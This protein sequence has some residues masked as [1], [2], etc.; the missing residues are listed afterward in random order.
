[1]RTGLIPALLFTA[2]G[3][4]AAGAG[5]TA[6]K[7]AAVRTFTDAALQLTFSYPAELRPMDPKAA[8]AMGQELLYGEDGAGDSSKMKSGAGC[9]R[10]LVAVG[11]DRPSKVR[12]AL[13]EID[14]SCVPPKAARNHKLMDQVLDGLAAQG[15]ESLGMMPM[16]DPVGFLLQ[17]HHAFF[18]SAE[19]T[20]VSATAI[21]GSTAEV[22]ATIAAEVEGHDGQPKI[23]AWHVVASDAAVFNRLLACPVTIGAGPAQALFPAQVR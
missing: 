9:T 13:Y 10:T 8:S 6:G 16:E 22:V 20:P 7:P 19:G 18:A 14:L 12:L 2:A 3:L 17:G 4:T 15:N 5:Q 1:M 11:E 21:Q 23:L